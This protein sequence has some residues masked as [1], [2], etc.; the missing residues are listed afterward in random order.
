MSAYRE[1]SPRHRHR[2][3]IVAGLRKDAGACEC[4]FAMNEENPVHFDNHIRP[5]ADFLLDDTVIFRFYERDDARFY[6][7]GSPSQAGCP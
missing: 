3:Q 4:S 6:P 5:H 1:S 7:D 2:E